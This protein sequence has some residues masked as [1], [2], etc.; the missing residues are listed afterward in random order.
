MF[1]SLRGSD[2]TCSCNFLGK[3]HINV[4][5]FCGLIFWESIYWHLSAPFA[6]PTGVSQGAGGR[7]VR[8]KTRGEATERRPHA[9][10]I[11]WNTEK[12]TKSLLHFY[13]YSREFYV[14]P[15]LCF[16]P[17]NKLFYTHFTPGVWDD[18]TR[19]ALL[20]LLQA[21]SSLRPHASRAG[22]V[23]R[24]ELPGFWWRRWRILQWL[25]HRK[26]K[27]STSSS[28]PFA[29]LRKNANV[30]THLVLLLPPV[31]HSE[32]ALY[33]V[34]FLANYAV[35]YMTCLF[36]FQSLDDLSNSCHDETM[37]LHA[38]I[39]DTGTHAHILRVLNTLLLWVY[40]HNV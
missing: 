12:C 36:C 17:V 4:L 13:L 26:H 27:P 6:Y 38:F 3:L 39:S 11:W 30:E 23:E 16:P 2:Y 20:P 19:W 10:D 32:A 34:T 31:I 5:A 14:L 15:C 33:C 35:K 28:L 7:G 37:H 8:N 22:H 24:A 18:A 21:E 40:C 1:W 29:W 25:S 9:R